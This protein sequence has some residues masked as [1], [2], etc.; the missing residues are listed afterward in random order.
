MLYL[1]IELMNNFYLRLSIEAVHWNES[2]ALKKS[3]LNKKKVQIFFNFLSQV[4]T[5]EKPTG[6]ENCTV[7]GGAL[8][9]YTCLKMANIDKKKA[10]ITWFKKNSH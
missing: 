10:L 2:T 3:V 8:K 7:C 6:Y 5:I 9:N 4:H 1:L